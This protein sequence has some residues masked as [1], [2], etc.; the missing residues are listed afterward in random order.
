[1][2]FINI[3]VN[4]LTKKE[5]I[6]LLVTILV[7]MILYQISSKFVEKTITNGKAEY[8]RKKRNTIVDLFR[9]LFKYVIGLI[10]ILVGLNLFG[11]DIKTLVAGL[12]IAATIIGLALQDTIKDIISGITILMENY[13]V[14]GDYVRYNN[15][16]GIVTELSLRTTKI[17]S[18]TGEV[19]TVCNRNI[20]EI[21]NISQK[22]ATVVIKIPVSHNIKINKVETIIKERILP[23]AE[24]IIDVR[25]GSSSYLG[26][27]D[28]SATSVTH[29]IS[30]D[31]KQESQ[32]QVKRDFLKIVLEQLEEN[33]IKIPYD[34]IEVHNA[35]S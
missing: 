22:E 4:F 35:K 7:G 23:L 21:I 26:I 25:K 13:Y 27:D 20:N 32:W 8:E 2:K 19:M 11:Y 15:F 9:H 34:K 14:A 5:V 16:Q 31:C 28:F 1:M 12:G 10:I 30:I 3:I 24:N 17:K 33:K 29:M 18:Y 6:W